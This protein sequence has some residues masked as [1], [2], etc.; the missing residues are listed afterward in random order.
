MPEETRYNYQAV[1]QCLSMGM[2]E[3]DG[4]CSLPH[5]VQTNPETLNNRVPYIHHCSRAEP[6]GSERSHFE[7]CLQNR[8]QSSATPHH[9]Q[10][11]K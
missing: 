5:A 1:Y 2:F 4:F 6:A 8:N 7:E 10:H 11:W 3:S 9:F